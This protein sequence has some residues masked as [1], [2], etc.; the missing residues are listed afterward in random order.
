MLTEMRT[1]DVSPD[2]RYNR[3][4]EATIKKILP[5]EATPDAIRVFA[6]YEWRLSDYAYWFMLGTLWVSYTG[7]SEL[8]DWIALFSSSRPNRETSLMKP[9][10]LAA[11]RKLPDPLTLYR[12]HRPNETQWISYALIPEK[13]AEFA[14]RRNVGELSEYRV[15]KNDVLALFL[16]RGEYE[17]LV[18]DQQRTEF[19]RRVPVVKV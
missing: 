15:A 2:F 16:R 1:R 11:F 6:R 19:V 10:E 3:T 12:A 18:L 4:D 14:A 8:R 9:S 17:V 7:W 13:A 5:F